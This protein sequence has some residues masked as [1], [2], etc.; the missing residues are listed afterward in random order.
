MPNNLVSAE[1]LRRM[2]I[3]E[4]GI[5]Y[6]VLVGSSPPAR[7]VGRKRRRNLV[8]D[9]PMP[10]LGIVLQAESLSG[11]FLF[12]NELQERRDLRAVFDQPTTIQLQITDKIGRRTRVSYTVDYLVIDQMRVIAYEIKSDH[13]LEEL[14]R[15]RPMDW[16]HESGTYKYLPAIRYFEKLGITHIT[17]PTSQLSAVRADNLRLLCSARRAKETRSL[18]KLRDAIEHIVA[19]EGAIRAG[20]ALDRLGECDATAALQ[21]IDSG[22]ISAAVDHTSFSDIRNVWLATSPSAA[23][24]AQ[25]ADQQLM[26]ML[27]ERGTLEEGELVDFE[28]HADVAC[29]LTIVKGVTDIGRKGKPVAPRTV[30]RYRHDY[31]QSGSDI[32][33]LVPGWSRSG[34]RTDRVSHSHRA[35]IAQ[36]MRDGRSD[37]DEPTR[38]QCYERYVRSF[39]A[40]QDATDQLAE[41]PIARST[42]YIWWSTLPNLAADARRRGGRRLENAM[43]DVYDPVTRT[44]ISTRAFACAHVDHWKADFFLVI[45]YHNGKKICARPWV[46]AMIDGYTREVLALWM[47]FSAPS[48]KSNCM[49]VRD[50]VRRHGRLPELIVVDGGSDFKSTHFAVMLATYEVTHIERPPEDPGFGQEIEGLFKLF[51]ERFA[52]GLPGFGLSIEQ[53]RAVSGAFKSQKRAV[54]NLMDGYEALEAFAFHGY[55]RTPQPTEVAKSR[56]D[57]RCESLAAFPFSGRSVDFDLRLMIATSID[58]PDSE[59][60]L[61]PRKGI[62]VDG[63]WYSSRRLLDFGGHKKQLKVRL[64]P[65]DPSVVYVSIDR[66]WFVCANTSVNLHGVLSDRRVIGK[67]CD[68]QDLRKLRGALRVE[69][70]RAAAELV[71]DTITRIAARAVPLPGSGAKGSLDEQGSDKPPEAATSPRFE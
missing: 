6:V 12:L 3:P 54:L 70:E 59:Y 16:V 48:R 7:K 63:Q 44:T 8:L 1:E 28:Y 32:S 15:V 53:S 2:G 55:N 9:V 41:R 22:R 14:C 38:H 57:A 69:M 62:H 11:E 31:Q 52:H 50:C 35:F 61:W 39:K 27:R 45:G 26:A 29:R 71:Q 23:N 18:R 10:L 56:T 19:G 20:A 34:N 58:A 30:R 5:E 40:F 49:V 60:T 13:Q 66:R 65:Y 67:A 47:S 43:S 68:L 33:S 64:E 21:L 42:Y 51:K 46:T 24:S 36:M 17:V 37:P 4:A 25:Q